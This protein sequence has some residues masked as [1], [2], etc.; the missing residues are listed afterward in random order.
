MLLYTFALQEDKVKAID[1]ST[2][3]RVCNSHYFNDGKKL[4]KVRSKVLE[5]SLLITI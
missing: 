4:L 2:T 5:A 3:N 1:V